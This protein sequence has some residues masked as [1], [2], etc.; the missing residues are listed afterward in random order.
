MSRDT[1]A[2]ARPCDLCARPA[3]RAAC[4]AFVCQHCHGNHVGMRSHWCGWM[5]AD[6]GEHQGEPVKGA[7]G[8]H[9]STTKHR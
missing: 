3:H 6:G 1:E 8:S 7:N 9:P 5:L 4:G 2:Q